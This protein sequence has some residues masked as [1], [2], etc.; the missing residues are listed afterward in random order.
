MMR[1]FAGVAALFAALALI[2]TGCGDGSG[3]DRQDTVPQ[4]I[5]EELDG[6]ELFWL[7][8]DDTGMKKW[9]NNRMLL[10]EEEE[11]GTGYVRIFFKPA[12]TTPAN[13]WRLRISFT[14]SEPHDIMYQCAWDKNFKWGR[15]NGTDNYADNTDGSG[16]PIECVPAAVFQGGGDTPGG[17]KWSDAAKPGDW[18]GITEPGD[19]TATRLD[20]ASMRGICLQLPFAEGTFTLTNVTFGPP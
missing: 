12:T 19:A 7:A 17:Y 1:K 15:S 11:N 18:W 16:G 8:S 3:K 5:E 2:V 10:R 6:T 4:G 20:L 13:N 9:A 14:I